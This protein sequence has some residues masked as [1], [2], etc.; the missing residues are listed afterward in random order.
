MDVEEPGNMGQPMAGVELKLA[1]VEG[2]LEARVRAPTVTPGYWRDDELTRRAFR[3]GRLYRFGDGV[4]FA[5]PGD[6]KGGFLS[7]AASPRISSSRPAPGSASGR[8]A[9]RWFPRW[10]RSP[11][12][13]SSPATTATTSRP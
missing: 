7:T 13:W 5:T 2:K 9:P 6:A 1:P 12:T 8:C 4:R 3:R 11:R 10:R